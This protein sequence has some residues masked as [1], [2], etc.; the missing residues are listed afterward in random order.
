MSSL[1]SPVD[2]SEPPS[3]L[4]VANTSSA[5]EQLA[6]EAAHVVVAQPILAAQRAFARGDFARTRALV[7][8][9]LNQRPD[10]ESRDA[11]ERLVARTQPDP[12]ARWVLGIAAVSVLA[13]TLIAYF[14]GRAALH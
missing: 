12:V 9:A 8:A 7:A 6:G 11:L 4:S 2:P 10:A 3:A 13:V 5:P 1:P 14:Q